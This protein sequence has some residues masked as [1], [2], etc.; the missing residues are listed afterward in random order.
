MGIKTLI[1]D[2][3]T[4]RKGTDS[5]VLPLDGQRKA[6]RW[7]VEDTILPR[8]LI[9]SGAG[10]KLI[11]CVAESRVFSLSCHMEGREV[12]AIDFAKT[13][14]SNALKAEVSEALGSFLTP[15]EAFNVDFAAFERPTEKG[16]ALRADT[17]LSPSR[18][19]TQEKAE[20]PTAEINA[21]SPS[22]RFL[23]IVAPDLQDSRSFAFGGG[24]PLEKLHK[25]LSAALNGPLL[26]VA[27]ADNPAQD[28]Y[29]FALDDTGGLAAQLHRQ[30][31]GKL[32]VAW[33]KIQQTTE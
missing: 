9:V 14:L 15:P 3:L 10:K 28:T 19:S 18:K 5:H 16:H 20:K 31:L 8:Q 7:L 6:L 2:R 22:Q 30:K 12:L 29:I 21:A 32:C 24:M 33:R 25:K 13:A 17:L 11:L 4:R 23:E 27:M 1:L 26:C